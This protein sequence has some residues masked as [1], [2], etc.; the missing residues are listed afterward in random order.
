VKEFLITDDQFK[1]YVD[2]HSGCKKMI[3]EDN[4]TMRNSYI[5]IDE[6]MRFLDCSNG[7]K[8]P[9]ASIFEIGVK[10]AYLRSNHD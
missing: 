9:T 4:T 7:G 10:E 2:R 5:N 8:E 6:K 3:P 1:Q